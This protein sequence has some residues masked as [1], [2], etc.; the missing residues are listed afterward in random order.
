MKTKFL[1][2][3]LCISFFLSFN[4]HVYSQNW[5]WAKSAN[6]NAPGGN[7]GNSV[8]SDANGNIFFSGG[9]RSASF[10]MGS[11]TFINSAPGSPDILIAKFDACGTLLWVKSYG[12]SGT[13]DGASVSTDIGGNVFVTGYFNSPTLTFGSTTFINSGSNDFFLAKFDGNGNLLWVKKESGTGS[14]TGK[15]VS[16]EPGGGAFVTGSF[17]GNA[18]FGTTTLTGANIGTS[19]AFIAK[20]DANG[21]LLWAKS[22][23]GTSTDEGYYLSSDPFG[24][25]FIVGPFN[26]STISFGSTT[27]TNGGGSDTF[28]AKYDASGNVLWAKRAGGTAWD[29]GKSIS[30]DPLGNVFVAGSTTSPSMTFGST[31]LINSGTFNS[32]IVKYDANGNVLW[33]KNGSGTNDIISNSISADPFGNVYVIGMFRPNSVTF[34]SITISPPASSFNPMFT[35]KF[36]TDGNELCGSALSSGGIFQNCVCTDP[37]G[38]AIIGGSFAVSPFIVGSTTLYKSSAQDMFIAKQTCSFSAVVSQTPSSCNASCTGTATVTHQNCNGP[39]TYSWNT[40]PIQTTQTATG[41]CEGNYQVI[42][43]DAS[44]NADTVLVTITQPDS[45][46][47]IVTT[48][49]ATCGSNIGSAT[50]TA[51]GGTGSLTYLW[52]GNETTSTIDGIGAGTY[53]VNITDSLGCVQTA[54]G[55]VTSTGGPTANAGTDITILSG[56]STQLNATGGGTYSWTP[57]LGLSCTN[58]ANPIA[59][60]LIT[61]D[62][63]VTITDVNGCTDTACVR[64]T[65]NSQLPCI[66]NYTVPTAFS[67]NND[68]HNDLFILHGWENCVTEFSMLIYDRWGEKVF[69]STDPAISWDGNFNGKLMG[70]GVFVYYIEANTSSGEKIT[71]KGNITLIR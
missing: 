55:N 21:N 2:F 7:Q 24:N 45:I 42:V 60:P 48:T 65:V 33:A 63:C 34:G 10:T 46:T 25:A 54:A 69:E 50:I 15:C 38:N 23:G 11:S 31:T 71:K 70:S 43:N 53:T 20:Y 26:S 61:T 28:I 32:F 44:S 22:A 40:L 64:V 51:N 49:P 1:G 39:Y 67:P 27:L 5:L 29:D 59:T 12:G 57:S 6:G 30:A 8:S 47:A 3:A 35:V 52:N 58:C 16:A 9:F 13:D 66:D 4:T 68:G 62:Y 17:Y 37:I 36:D 14:L 19:D 41:L 56:T 18:M